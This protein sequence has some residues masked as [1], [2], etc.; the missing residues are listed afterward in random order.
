MKL[1]N[2]KGFILVE[3]LVVTLFVT[4]LFILVYQNLVPSIGEYEAMT[5]YDD[6]DSVYA[7]NVYKQSLLRYGNMDYIDSYLTSH[8]YL[9]ITNC[10]DS[11]IYKNSDYCKKIRALT[12]NMRPII[13]AL[14]K[15]AE[16]N[17]RIN[18]L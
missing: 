1:L 2:K 17:D 16:T 5:S 11:N 15:S 3:T 8:T 13:V 18:A 6:I 12:Y 9:D 4:T 7:A 10:D 14:S